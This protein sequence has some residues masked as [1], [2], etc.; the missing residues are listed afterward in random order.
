[1]IGLFDLAR[2]TLS[3]ESDFQNQLH[4]LYKI[5]HELYV[6]ASINSKSIHTVLLRI[7]VHFLTS[8]RSFILHSKFFLY[9]V[10]VV[11]SVD[12]IRDCNTT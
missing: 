1:M 9:V 12:M 5:F 10:D 11:Y 8:F 2:L 6:V 4:G 3:L 7:V